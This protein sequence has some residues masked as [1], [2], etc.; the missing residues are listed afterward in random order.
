MNAALDTNIISFWMK[1][2]YDI[3]NK[4]TK[5][6]LDGDTVIIPPVTYYEVIRGLYADDANRK[7][8]LFT[9]LC[10][11]FGVNEMDKATWTEAARL[12]AEHKK[13]GH[14][15]G[16]TDLLQAAFCI[17]HKYTLVTNNTKHFSH[18]SNLKIIDWAS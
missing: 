14:P 8:K 16:D 18:I 12:Y 10:E 11:R 5:T 6:V 3:E 9:S 13:I 7:L 1:G 15:V 4:M 17:R 2:L